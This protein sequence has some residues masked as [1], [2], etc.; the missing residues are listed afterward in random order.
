MAIRKF[1]TASVSAGSNKS[2]KL[3]DQETFQSGMFAIATILLTSDQSVVTF[4]GISSTYT[5]LQLRYMAKCTQTGTGYS[6]M[7]IRFNSDSGTNYSGHELVGD[8]STATSGGA[9]TD[10]AASQSQIQ[11]RWPQTSAQ[12]SVGVIDLLDY[13]NT[14]KNTTLKALAGFDNNGSGNAMFTSGAWYNTAAITT[15]SIYPKHN[16]IISGSHFALYGIKSA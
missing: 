1:S 7:Q 15:I 13:A 11:I 12:F 9:G 4:S 8:G 5:H 6:V 10:A 14:S 16:S 3:W 2:T